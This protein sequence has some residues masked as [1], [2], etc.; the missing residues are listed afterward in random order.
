MLTQHIFV[1][2]VYETKET[3][4]SLNVYA[5]AVAGTFVTRLRPNSILDGSVAK[6]L[7]F[8]VKG[9]SKR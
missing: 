4:Q 1:G 2:C 7:H 9:K 3:S 6:S 8:E 5:G